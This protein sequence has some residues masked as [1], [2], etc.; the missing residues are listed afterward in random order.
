MPSLGVATI[1]SARALFKT[2]RSFSVPTAKEQ[3]L[4]D[5]SDDK[6][7]FYY[8]QSTTLLFLTKS[9]IVAFVFYPA[10]T[11]HSW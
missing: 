7:I 11:L 1:Q 9:T 6:V 2:Q 5:E 8:Q 3:K 4:L 10:L